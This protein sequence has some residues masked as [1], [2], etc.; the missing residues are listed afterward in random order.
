MGYVARQRNQIHGTM[1]APVSI[2]IPTLNSVQGLGPTLASVYEGVSSGL[3]CEVIFADGGS[4]DEI[5]KLAGDLGAELVRS[6][7]GRGTQM[8]AGAKA[9][10]GEWLLFLHSDTALSEGWAHDIRKHMVECHDHPG[11]FRLAFDAKGFAPWF[12]SGWANIRAALFGLPYG[13]QGLLVSRLEYNRAGGFDN[14]PLMED[15][16]LVRRLPR[17]RRMGATAITSAERY[18]SDGWFR[19]GLRNLT[20]LLLYF[21]GAPPENLAKR[22]R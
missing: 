16:Q 5:G 20:I 19:R 3:V 15:V 1:T 9:S 22:Y 7:K 14:I 11:Y 10:R 6:P 21:L 2:I 8:A 12:V 4:D 17:P 13:D 18:Q